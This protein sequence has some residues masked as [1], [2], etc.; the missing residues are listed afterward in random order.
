MCGIVACR[1]DA[2][3]APF[4]IG[5]LALLEYR[6]YDSAGVTVRTTG[7]ITATS[8]TIARVESLSHKLAGWSG[9]TLPG[10]GIGHTRWATHGAVTET[11]AHPHLDCSGRV[12]IVHNG[13]IENAEALRREL[14]A[15]GHRLITQV[16]S[17]VI[18]HLVEEELRESGDLRAAVEA[19]I[20]RLTGSWA[21]VA[22]DADTGRL[23][24]ATHRSPLLVASSPSGVFAASDVQ[25]IGSRVD[26]FQAMR[27]GDVVE[28]AD[29]LIWTRDGQPATPPPFVRSSWTAVVRD[30]DGHPDF[31]G[32]EIAEQP[33]TAARIIDQLAP[34]IAN[35]A[36]WEGLGI[37]D[38][39]RV[40]VLGCGTSLNAGRVVGSAFGA[41]G[42][43]PVSSIIAS[44]ASET[45]LE[46]GTLV[47]ALSQS[48]ET[49]DVLRAIE[50]LDL[51]ES[52]LLALTNT[53]HS[54][55]ARTADSV[56]DCQAGPE[57]GVAATKTFVAQAISG[58]AMALSALVA[59]GRMS[60]ETALLHVDDLRRLPDLLAHA[61]AVSHDRIPPLIDALHD[62]S[63]YLFLGRGSGV[64]YAAEGALKLKELSYRWAEHYPAGE[65]KHGP[66]ALIELGTPVVVIDSGDPRIESNISEVEARGG[67]V[68][69][70]GGAGST[71]P[72]LGLSLGTPMPGG[73]D[74]WGPLESV[75]PL[76]VLARD[77]ALSLGR[78][79]DKPRNLAKSVTVE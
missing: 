19:T 38:F 4:L 49:A 51:A 72:A 16:D 26:G 65:L 53:A 44:E 6:G 52:S 24:A 29:E 57:I 18:S 75:V 77:L 63:G 73:M 39:R 28:L 78:D 12:S 43:L 76:Q 11:N 55:L 9:A 13:I 68:I 2:P 58:V 23:V 30:L 32:K 33:E 61:I 21:I 69:R 15:R 14:A 10:A 74:R 8:R 62:A 56:L 1:T 37:P 20:A 46:P 45:V 25:A 17:E 66:L 47:I 7:G 31:M 3:V 59:T 64:V 36:L 41:L 35:G 27:D 79:V 67:R 54:T 5:A 50:D 48:G 22:L 71:I 40:A 60:R 42:R 70:I 34:G